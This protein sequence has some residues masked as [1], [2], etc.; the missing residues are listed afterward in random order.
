MY[1]CVLRT[2]SRK[3]SRAQRKIIILALCNSL[4]YDSGT[5]SDTDGKSTL[6]PYLQIIK[7]Q[8]FK[9][10]WKELITPWR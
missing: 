2:K 3:I 1:R 7:T 5:I 8:N 4:H 9:E 6:I 10:I